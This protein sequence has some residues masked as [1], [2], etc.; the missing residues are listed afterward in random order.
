MKAVLNNLYLVDGFFVNP[1]LIRNKFNNQNIGNSDRPN[2]YSDNLQKGL[3]IDSKGR[4]DS[5]CKL[6]DNCLI[7]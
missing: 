7:L 1:N 4:N 6:E 2:L 5:C 3:I